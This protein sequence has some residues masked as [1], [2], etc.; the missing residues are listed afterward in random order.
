MYVSVFLEPTNALVTALVDH[1]TFISNLVATQVCSVQKLPERVK[2]ISLW[3]GVADELLAMKNMNGFIAVSEGLCS[4]PVQRLQNTFNLLKIQDPNLTISY[5]RIKNEL[6]I[7]KNSPIAYPSVP[8][9]RD[10]VHEIDQLS[11]TPD[12][13][14]GLHNWDKRM[15]FLKYLNVVKKLQASGSSCFGEI[16][17]NPKFRASIAREQ[18]WDPHQLRT[19]SCLL[20]EEWTFLSPQ[21]E[22]E[23]VLRAIPLPWKVPNYSKGKGWKKIGNFFT[24]ELESQTQ[25]YWDFLAFFNQ[26]FHAST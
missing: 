18:I 20:E 25:K 9:F 8:Y 7:H 4:Y 22:Q 16:P 1:C 21:E 19:Q 6:E 14:D 26:V 11:E 2:A 10:V 15:E 3:I 13:V 17:K 5:Q 12:F 23:K 24:M